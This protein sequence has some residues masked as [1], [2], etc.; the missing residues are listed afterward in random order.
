M[1]D[2][3]ANAWRAAVSLPRSHL[4]IDGRENR[5]E[6][7][8]LHIFFLEENRWLIRINDSDYV[9]RSSCRENLRAPRGNLSLFLPHSLA[10]VVPRPAWLTLSIKPG[11]QSQRARER[12]ARTTLISSVEPNHE[13]DAADDVSFDFGEYFA[14]SS[15]NCCFLRSWYNAPKL[16]RVWGC[17]ETIC[18]RWPPTFGWANVPTSWLRFGA[19]LVLP[20]NDREAG[21]GTQSS[22]SLWEQLIWVL[23][24]RWTFSGFPNDIDKLSATLSR[25]V[26][27]WQGTCGRTSCVHES[28]VSPLLFW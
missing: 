4:C 17:W 27:I 7:P 1:Y 10:A 18:H 6:F 26:Q 20:T 25:R 13:R 19:F 5:A 15:F 14:L 16:L 2:A 11:S 3:D 21:S 24:A 22:S 23:T 12:A 8:K 28:L 9:N